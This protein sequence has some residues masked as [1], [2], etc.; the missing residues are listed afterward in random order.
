M[1][2]DE[3]NLD[4]FWSKDGN[5]NPEFFIINEAIIKGL[6]VLG[7]DNEPCFEG[8]RITAPTIQFSFDEGF[9][10]QLFSMMNELTKLL[11]KE[12]QRV[13]T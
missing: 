11:S 8:A 7:E 3:N 10:E 12:E 6:C 13:L 5:G 9:K 2:L 4:A 1:E